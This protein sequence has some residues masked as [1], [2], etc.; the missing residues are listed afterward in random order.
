MNISSLAVAVTFF[1]N[2]DKLIYLEKALSNLHEFADTV[3][4]YIITN[5]RESNEKEQIE[6]ILPNYENVKNQILVPHLIG[7]PYLL[8]WSHKDIFKHLIDAHRNISYFLYIEDDIYLTYDNIQYYLE[9]NVLLEKRKFIPSF[10]RYEIYDSKKYAIDIMKRQ[11]FDAMGKLIFKDDYSYVN[12]S[13][14]YQ[15]LYLLSH[16]MMEQYYKSPAYNPDYNTVWPIREMSTAT[17]SFY[18][19]PQGFTSRNLVGC[20]I[21]D[22]NVSFDERCLIHHLP[23]KYVNDPENLKKLFVIDDIFY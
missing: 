6:Q 22:G 9:A 3:F 1:Y 16:K 20:N 4:L 17:I 15:G 23:D 2:Q 12:L 21:N 10:V 18:N 19:V 11:K 8:T 14:P 13:Y 7:H 5:T